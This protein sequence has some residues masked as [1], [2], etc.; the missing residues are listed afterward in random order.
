MG[1]GL[2]PQLCDSFVPDGSKCHSRNELGVVHGRFSDVMALDTP[3]LQ[4]SF[5]VLTSFLLRGD[6]ILPKKELPLSPWVSTASFGT[7]GL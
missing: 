2:W 6:N 1:C 5:L 4:C 3:G 7:W